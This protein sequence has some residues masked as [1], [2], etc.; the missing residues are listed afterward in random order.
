[1]KEECRGMRLEFVQF[2]LI[3][4]KLR[5]HFSYCSLCA[6][7]ISLEKIAYHFN[8]L[9]DKISWR[10]A[11]HKIPFHFPLESSRREGSN[12]TPPLGLEGGVRTPL[13]ASSPGGG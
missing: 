10:F 1:M 2:H 4:K 7:K 9:L 12:P 3:P 11:P 6:K 13:P 8:T 5:A